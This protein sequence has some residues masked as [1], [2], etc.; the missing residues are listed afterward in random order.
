MSIK[1]FLSVTIDNVEFAKDFQ[2]FVTVQF[3]N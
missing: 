1:Y 2:Y 3:Q